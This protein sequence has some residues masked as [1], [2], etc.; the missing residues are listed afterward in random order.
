MRKLVHMYRGSGRAEAD[1]PDGYTEGARHAMLVFLAGFSDQYDW[2]R[3]E[4]VAQAQ[5]WRDVEFTK[6]GKITTEAIADQD[7][8]LRERYA[9]ALAD[10]SALVVYAAAE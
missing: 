6:A 5:G 4:Q 7:P 1:H 3:A 8:T 9:A 10:G 2:A